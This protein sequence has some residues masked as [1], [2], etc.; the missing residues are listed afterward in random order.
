[1]SSISSLS[2]LNYN[3]FLLLA[4]LDS[5]S[6]SSASS[7][8]STTNASTT[9]AAAATTGTA[10]ASTTTGTTA[11]GSSSLWNQL[12]TA[13][14][15][16]IQTA[17][18]SGN[19]S[20]PCFGP[21]DCREQG[22]ATKRHQSGYLRTATLRANAEGTPPSSPPRRREQRKPNERRQFASVRHV[23]C[24]RQHRRHDRRGGGSGNT[25]PAI[26]RSAHAAFRHFEWLSGQRAS[27][28]ACPPK[29]WV[30]Y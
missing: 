13:F 1:M 6:T 4:L 18:Q 16:A 30:K 12:T 3:P 10:A 21:A 28:A 29:A 15:N 17:E 14:N 25:Q 5:Q 22:L 7:A 27:I 9:A 23:H 20:K 24:D 11:T 8:A 26:Y 19:T 2:G